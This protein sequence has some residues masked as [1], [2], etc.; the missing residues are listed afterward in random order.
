ML[1]GKN[2]TRG[3]GAGGFPEVA[4]KCA[5]GSRDEISKALGDTELVFLTAGIGGGTGT[6]AAPIVADIAKKNGAVVVAM[7][8]YPFS[9]ERARTEKAKW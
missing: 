2:L 4:R 1:I 6:G 5:E 7:V 3:L 9:L 8:K